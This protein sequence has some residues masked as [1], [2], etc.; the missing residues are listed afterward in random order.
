MN[1]HVPT[2]Q[3]K[4]L[5]INHLKWFEQDKRTVAIFQVVA[6]LERHNHLGEKLKTKQNNQVRSLGI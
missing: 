2:A 6:C 5:G 3:F 4:K 1:I